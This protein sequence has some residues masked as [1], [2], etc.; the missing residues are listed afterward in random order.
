MD[1]AEEVRNYE[2][3]LSDFKM[4]I[5]SRYL[6]TNYLERGHDEHV[7]RILDIKSGCLMMKYL[8]GMR[9]HHQLVTEQYYLM[10][11]RQD[12]IL[13]NL[14][15]LE[16]R[17][18][19]L[20]NDDVPEDLFDFRVTGSLTQ[21]FFWGF[22]R[23]FSLKTGKLA[24]TC[25]LASCTL[26]EFPSSRFSPANPRPFYLNLAIMDLRLTAKQMSQWPRMSPWSAPAELHFSQK[27]IARLHPNYEL[28]EYVPDKEMRSFREVANGICVYETPRAPREG[29]MADGFCTL[30]WRSK[31]M[32]LALEKWLEVQC[33]LCHV[34]DK[35]NGKP[36]LP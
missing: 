36:E 28:E 3:P 13:I 20:R 32:P 21:S 29:Y 22:I 27:A 14:D 24:V 9:I 18:Q 6:I 34:Q 19:V 10:A 8:W 1:E 26:D 2:Q 16:A 33:F 31:K 12:S 35:P 17:K 25:N 15:E 7:V 23:L 5:T 30:K 11:T 4:H